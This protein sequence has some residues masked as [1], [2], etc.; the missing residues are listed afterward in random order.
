VR[1]SM[2]SPTSP[3]SIFAINM[4]APYVGPMLANAAVGGV[5]FAV[6]RA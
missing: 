2:I 5:K 3:F 1:K 6:Y 4:N